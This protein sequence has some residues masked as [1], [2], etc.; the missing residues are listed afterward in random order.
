MLRPT[1]RPPL[2]KG[3]G[4][5]CLKVRAIQQPDPNLQGLSPSVCLRINLGQKRGHLS[6]WIDRLPQ[7]AQ[8]KPVSLVQESSPARRE[9]VQMKKTTKF[10]V[11][12]RELV[13]C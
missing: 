7:P 10:Q 8:E 11:T 3:R 6:T 13:S 2:Q 5:A 12:F 1:C 9:L 4:G